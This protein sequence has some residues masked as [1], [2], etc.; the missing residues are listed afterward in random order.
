MKFK[1]SKKKYLQKLMKI[2][3]SF[4]IIV[5]F[6]KEGK[7]TGVIAEHYYI[8]LNKNSSYYDR[9]SQYCDKQW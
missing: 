2:L 8:S 3:S 5:M 9:Y 4:G 6:N 7:I 1:I